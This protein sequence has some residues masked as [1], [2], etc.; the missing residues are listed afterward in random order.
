MRIS[1]KGVGR[2][3][4]VGEGLATATAKAALM[5]NDEGDELFLGVGAWEW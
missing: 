4:L 3:M 1:G 2:P 5:G